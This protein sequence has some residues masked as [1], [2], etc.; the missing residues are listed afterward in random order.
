MMLRGKPRRRSVRLEDGWSVGI[1]SPSCILEGTSNGPVTSFTTPHTSPS[2]TAPSRRQ[3]QRKPAMPAQPGARNL[4]FG[5]A[6]AAL[7][8]A[9]QR[10]AVIVRRI[11]QPADT[12]SGPMS[13][14]PED[15]RARY[16]ASIYGVT[17]N[18]ALPA[19]RRPA[20]V[21]RVPIVRTRCPMTSKETSDGHDHAVQARTTPARPTMIPAA[22]VSPNS[23]SDPDRPDRNPHPARRL[24]RR[25]PVQPA[26]GLAFEPAA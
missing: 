25:R 6:T 23:G 9:G 19:G 5:R 4:R 10:L 15:I 17:E 18:A 2:S 20:L 7:A 3:V 13:Q 21:A 22:A 24:A 8:Q 14:T 26:P 12:F 1:A 16:S 11:G